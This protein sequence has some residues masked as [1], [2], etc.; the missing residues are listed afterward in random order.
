MKR[1]IGILLIFAMTLSLGACGLQGG[2]TNDET[3]SLSDEKLNEK[4]DEKIAE[5]NDL[6]EGNAELWNRL[7]ENSDAAPDLLSDDT[8]Y[9]WYFSEQV[10]ANIE[11]F[12][13][14]ELKLLERDIEK[15]KEIENDLAVLNK[16]HDKRSDSESD[17]VQT[18]PSFEGETF[19]GKK[20]DSSLFKDNAVTVVNFWFNSCP[21]CVAEL[22]ALSELNAALKDKEGAVI[23]INT[24]TFDGN[25]QM[26]S[27]AKEILEK[28]GADYTNLWVGSDSTLA[29]F[30]QGFVGYPIT[31]VVDRNGEI[32]GEPVLGGIDNQTIKELLQKQI[33]MAVLQEQSN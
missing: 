1:W 13:A 6:L 28:Q 7:F 2:N 19:D 11:L 18:F 25:E 5:I 10:K 17:S 26:I 8:L 14:D 29:L 9:S 33:D 12:S 3:A 20:I 32:V 16:E 31:Y 30:T 21:S 15:I 24:D 27:D 23:G 22:E 4:I